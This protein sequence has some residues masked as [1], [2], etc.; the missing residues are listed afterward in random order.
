MSGNGTPQGT[1]RSAV[2]S[3]AVVTRAQGAVWV[4]S[5]ATERTLPGEE[6][7]ASGFTKNPAAVRLPFP[8]NHFSA[9]ERV[10]SAAGLPSSSREL[11]PILLNARATFVEC[12]FEGRVCRSKRAFAANSREPRG[13][14]MTRRANSQTRSASKTGSIRPTG[15]RDGR[16][17]AESALRRWSDTVARR[18]QS[19]G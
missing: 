6:R 4:A 17:T 7:G 2:H 16:L 5:A 13:V 9:P 18:G 10:W 11:D 19:G 14:K 1:D 3:P 8:R 12:R 15:A